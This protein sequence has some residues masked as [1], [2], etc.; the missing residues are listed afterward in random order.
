[1]YNPYKLLIFEWSIN[2][3][4]LSIYEVFEA[5]DILKPK[6][7]SIHGV[8]RFDTVKEAYRILLGDICP[9]T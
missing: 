4:G 6:S 9:E 5:L 7:Y 8:E 3:V 2:T 1:M